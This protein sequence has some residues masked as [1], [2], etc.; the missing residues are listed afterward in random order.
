MSLSPPLTI[1]DDP[2]DFS[3]IDYDDHFS[4]NYGSFDDVGKEREQTPKTMGGDSWRFT[5]SMLDP[6]SY[7]FSSFA[8]QPPGY[9][10][11]TPGG[12][13]TL[14]HS[15]AGDLHTP[16]MGMNTPLSMPHSGGALPADAN[17]N[18]H[19]FH[20]SMYTHQSF[21]N[22]FVTQASFAPAQF[23]HQDSG[24]EGM[25]HSNHD[26]PLDTHGQQFNQATM[27]GLDMAPPA[28]PEQDK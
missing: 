5:P 17:V 6:N 3:Y 25:E 19:H 9:Y 15:Q 2:N 20:P 7:S 28:L 14:Y 27:G 13:N 1:M 26:S 21:V 18:M 23:V 16:G 8:N 10:T 11:P 12:L 22:P 4:Q 24:F